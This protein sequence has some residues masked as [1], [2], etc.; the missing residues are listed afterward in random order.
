MFEI[1]K[2][3]KDEVEAF[4]QIRLESL[5]DSS[6]AF[7]S[8]YEESLHVDFAARIPEIDN[9]EAAIFV[10]E[11][12]DSLVAMIGIMR[13]DRSKMRHKAHI[14]GVYVRPAG[15]QQGLA[16]KLMETAIQFGKNMEGVTHLQLT[17]TS[18]NSTAIKLYE[19]LGFVRYGV[20]SA[21]VIIDG[22]PYDHDL[23]EK[24]L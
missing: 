2:L 9:Q 15:R 6:S 8:S 24:R 10:A 14:W 21:A 19:S 4:K 13:K 20:E 23:M 12:D 17:V 22:I 7:G 1:R 16:R 5:R 11:K 3:R 18:N